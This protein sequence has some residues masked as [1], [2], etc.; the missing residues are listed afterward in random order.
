[1]SD[2]CKIYPRKMYASPKGIE[3]SLYFSCPTAAK[4]LLQSTPVTVRKVDIC[5]NSFHFIYPK[6]VPYY[7]PEKL[8]KSNIKHYYY[9]IEDG[10]IQIIQD[11]HLT[12]KDRL[13]AVYQVLGRLAALDGTPQTL[14]SISQTF[15][16]R[17]SISVETDYDLHLSLLYQT[18][19][20][21]MKAKAEVKE[22]LS[23][24]FKA[25]AIQETVDSTLDILKGEEGSMLLD[26]EVYH[27]KLEWYYSLPQEN[28]NIVWENYFVNYIFSKEFYV[29]DWKTTVFKMLLLR[30]LV[31]FY[32]VALQT[33]HPKAATEQVLI[34]AIIEVDTLISHNKSY[35]HD[36]WDE[37]QKKQDLRQVEVVLNLA[38]A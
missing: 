17:S 38:Y 13:F 1:M 31:Q 34:Q 7:I 3:F 9:I 21:I 33:L 23:Y 24:L 20:P 8:P 19:E 15:F 5:D 2:T 28:A 37:F 36:L 26:A 6:K 10:L 22:S 32:A 25:L 4:L 35:A 27:E 14:E 12:I 11:R 29:A 30:T 16:S 18:F